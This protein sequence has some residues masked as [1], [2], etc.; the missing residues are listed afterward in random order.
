MLP[1][2]PPSPPIPLLVDVVSPPLVLVAVVVV[3]SLQPGAAPAAMAAPTTAI[4]PARCQKRVRLLSVMML[5][6]CGLR[7]RALFPRTTRQIAL[8]TGEL[9]GAIARTPQPPGRLH[10]RAEKLIT[11]C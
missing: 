11:S 9:P 8:A 6:S 2:A 1:P 10:L 4:G 5:S 3:S 7:D